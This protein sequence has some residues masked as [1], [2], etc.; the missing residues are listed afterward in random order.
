MLKI[1]D[2]VTDKAPAAIAADPSGKIKANCEALAHEVISQVVEYVVKAAH[3][4]RPL[5]GVHELVFHIEAAEVARQAHRAARLLGWGPDTI[6]VEV[7]MLAFGNGAIRT[8]EVPCDKFP[9]TSDTD[10]LEAVFYYGQNDF[11]PKPFPSVSVGDVIRLGGAR[12]RVEGMGF[13]KLA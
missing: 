6:N 3:G 12:F 2:G 9:L 11:Q 4:P 5:G 13:K 1:A 8:V 7:E 10:A